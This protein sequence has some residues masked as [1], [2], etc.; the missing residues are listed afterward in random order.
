MNRMPSNRTTVITALA[1][2]LLLSTGVAAQGAAADTATASLEDHL[3]PDS[4]AGDTLLVNGR[5]YPL[6]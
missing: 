3:G 6:Q 4:A 5:A 1:C 2:G